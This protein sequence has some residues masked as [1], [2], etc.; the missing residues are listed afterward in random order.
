MFEIYL[1]PRADSP[2]RSLLVLLDEE[3]ARNFASVV[4]GLLDDGYV[5][6]AEGLS[7]FVRDRSAKT[8]SVPEATSW[9]WADDDEE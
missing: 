4:D 1:A 3:A 8:D 7:V 9:S 5:A 6:D 2:G